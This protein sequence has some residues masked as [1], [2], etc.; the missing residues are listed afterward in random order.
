VPAVRAAGFTAVTVPAVALAHLAVTGGL[1]P[2]GLML[3]VALLAAVA[4]GSAGHAGTPRLLATLA[5]AQLAGHGVLYLA[6][7]RPD[8]GCLPT[9]GRGARIGVDLALLRPDA[10]CGPG[11]YTSGAGLLA[12]VAVVLLALT[13]LTGQV[14][15]ATGG[16]LLLRALEASWRAIRALA[17]RIVPPLPRPL[18]VTT[19]ARP[20]PVLVIR[21]PVPAPA[22][23]PLRRRGPPT[24]R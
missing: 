15:V 14:L 21:P 12:A 13:V 19:G 24:A 5:G 9:M 3:L 6:L 22:G 4:G 20:F 10:A 17:A 18:V 7:G 23:T 8:A 16:A 11:G 1:P 2:A